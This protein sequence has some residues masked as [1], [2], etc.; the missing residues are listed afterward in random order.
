MGHFLEDVDL[1]T[2]APP[3]TSQTSNA[4]T[5]RITAAKHSGYK[6]NPTNAAKSHRK[7]ERLRDRQRRANKECPKQDSLF[8]YTFFC[9]LPEAL[10]MGLRLLAVSLGIHAFMWFINFYPGQKSDDTM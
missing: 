3:T 8:W 5:K 7:Q 10:T 6:G 9:Y 4:M 2:Q 1:I